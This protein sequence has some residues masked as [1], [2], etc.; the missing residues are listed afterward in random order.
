MD[1]LR[2]I[3]PGHP[4]NDCGYGELH[5]VAKGRP[6]GTEA[7]LRELPDGVFVALAD[8]PEQPIPLWHGDL[9]HWT[10]EG[11]HPPK[12]V[13]SDAPVKVLTP[14]AT[15]EVMNAGYEPAVALTDVV[16]AKEM[17]S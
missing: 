5:R 10:H 1:D 14:S 3:V 12:V 8:A 4:S 6:I 9:H 2:A 16:T 13:T 17:P 7:S 15:A 11:Y